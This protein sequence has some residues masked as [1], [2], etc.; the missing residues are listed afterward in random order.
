VGSGNVVHNL[1][2]LDW[3][4]PEEGFDWSHRFDDEARRLLTSAPEDVLKLAGHPDFANASPTP[5]HFIPLLYLAGLAQA[6]GSGADVMVDGYAY[7]GLSMTA[8]RLG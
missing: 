5:D 3:S 7:G 4:L 1:G 6:A 2:R 8:Y